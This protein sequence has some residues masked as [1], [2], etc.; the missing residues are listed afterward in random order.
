MSFI[1]FCCNFCACYIPIRSWYAFKI[2]LNT[3]RHSRLALKK[4]SYLEKYLDNF[5]VN[6]TKFSQMT[7]HMEVEEIAELRHSWEVKLL[8]IV[9]EDLNTQ[10][11]TKNPTRLLEESYCLRCIACNKEF[12]TFGEG[13]EHRT[14]QKHYEK[15]R[16]LGCEE[17]KLTFPLVVSDEE[18]EDEEEEET[19]DLEEV[20]VPRK[21]LKLRD[22]A[23]PSVSRTPS[24]VT[25]TI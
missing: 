10:R 3:K 4:K 18:E 8:E 14:S 23:R 16:E 22:N 17:F 9:T 2:H 5:P 24:P 12:R 7:D 13:M 25:P 1:Q 19:S 21:V 15:C 20:V 6:R 11:S